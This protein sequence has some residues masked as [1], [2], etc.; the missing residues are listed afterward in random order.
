MRSW[1]RRLHRLL[2]ARPTF[3]RPQPCRL[4][5]EPLESRCVLSGNVLQTNLVSDLPGVAAHT[6]P[7]LVNPWGISESG[8]SP[9]WISDNNAGVS[10]L[11]NS[12]GLPLSLV[13]SIPS[14]GDP[15]GASGTPTGTVFNIDGG[16]TG[17]FM[18]SGF[19]NPKSGPPVATSAAAVFLF[20]TEDGTIVGW[21]PGVN[22]QGF[23]PTKAGTYAIIAVDNSGNNFTEPDP[24]KQTGAV[25]KGMSIAQSTSAIFSGDPAS[26]TVLYLTNFRSGQVEV[27][28]PTFTQIKLPKGAFSD[29]TLPDGYAPFNVQVLGKKVYV[30]YAKQDKAKHDDDAGPH[31]GFVDVFNLDGTPGLSG[32]QM[33]L[34]SRGP[35]DSPWGLVLAPSSFGSLGGDL[36]VGNFGNGHINA[37]NPTTG[38]FLGELK[39]PDGEPIVIDGLWALK[40]GN[41]GAGGDTDKVYFTAGLFGE[42]HGLFGS[43]TPVAA[44]SHEADEQVTEEQMVQAALDVVQIDLNTLQQDIAGGASQATI[45]QDLQS[46]QAALIDLVH[47]EAQFAHD[48]RAD[49]GIALHTGK[50]SDR[51][52]DLDARDDVFTGIG[53]GR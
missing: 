6:D 25:Y 41:G 23:D 7:N 42:T 29:P 31:R 30:T 53:R 49:A 38:G 52:S 9:F 43:L 39:D 34:I 20:A 19:N 28:D 10:T 32:G 14:P 33:R 50:D 1:S 11:Y 46:L 17:G 15:L 4:I 5:V 47:A 24:L 36:L 37:F 51:G 27:Y 12:T 18:V 13:V 44:G 35:L 21:N 16:P 45:H 48:V 3:R 40:V 8:G 26:T 22:P 2:A